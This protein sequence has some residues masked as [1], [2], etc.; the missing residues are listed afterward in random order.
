MVAGKVR[1]AALGLVFV[2]AASMP[3]A[4]LSAEEPAGD[5]Y[6]GPPPDAPV[7]N[8]LA[9]VS[10]GTVLRC[11]AD[12]SGAAASEIDGSGIRTARVLGPDALYVVCGPCLDTEHLTEPGLVRIYSSGDI[13]YSSGVSA[14]RVYRVTYM[15]AGG[16]PEH[17]IFVKLPFK[18]RAGMRYRVVFNSPGRRPLAAGRSKAEVTVS[19]KDAYG[20]G[21]RAAACGYPPGSPRKAYMSSWMG[22][23]GTYDFGRAAEKFE[24]RDAFTH[25]VL[26]AGRTAPYGGDAGGAVLDFSEYKGGGVVYLAV[27]G[28]GRSIR[29][30]L[31]PYGYAKMAEAAARL[32]VSGRAGGEG[33]LLFCGQNSAAAG[34]APEE[35][36]MFAEAA[37][38]AFPGAYGGASAAERLRYSAG[39]AWAAAIFRKAGDSEYAAE[40]TERALK[41]RGGLKAADAA[42]PGYAAL[43]AAAFAAATG[44]DA[45]IEEFERAAAAAG[46]PEVLVGGDAVPW[47]CALCIYAGLP[48]GKGSE[49]LKARLTG[50]LDQFVSSA[51]PHSG[52]P[53]AVFAAGALR[54]LSGG[55]RSSADAVLYGFNETICGGAPQ[56]FID[57]R[58]ED[59]PGGA[60]FRFPQPDENGTIRIPRDDAAPGSDRCDDSISAAAYS[61]G[62]FLPAAPDPGDGKGRRSGAGGK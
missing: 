35:V 36:R 9:R 33:M 55:R 11:A 48:A 38:K 1:F 50:A 15:G 54:G 40:L 3:A 5:A 51:D 59:L 44:E 43:T 10:A 17:G 52:D 2:F 21:F 30:S 8:R 60:S 25:K 18:M 49:E 57:C 53:A 13:M 41:V 7:T 32:A 27:P 62:V 45:Y 61:F 58:A 29:F 6:E 24:L 42:S 28:C 47:A 19:G 46:L 12:T 37:L 39:I 34:Y 16:T 14:S 56:S 23:G 26:F 31:S 4:S 22:D 20:A